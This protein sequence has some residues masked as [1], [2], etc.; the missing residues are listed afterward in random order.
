M[1]ARTVLIRLVALTLL[2]MSACHWERHYVVTGLPVGDNRS[3]IILADT[4]AEI[5][6][7]IYY[8]VKIGGETVVSTCLICQAAKD[9]DSLNF[10]TLTASGGTLV[11]LY[12]ETD[13]ERILALY[14]FSRGGSWPR[15]APG[16]WNSEIDS[17]GEELL[18]QLQQE[19]PNS[20]LRLSGGAACGIKVPMNQ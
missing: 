5:S 12:E 4:A 9:V 15:G 20:N 3:I 6:T 7:G 14:D 16:E 17:R 11:A 8:Q 19:Y 13:P 18:K 2:V 10:K 1:V